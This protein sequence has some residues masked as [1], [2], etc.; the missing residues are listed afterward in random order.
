MAERGEVALMNKKVITA[1]A[2]EVAENPRARSA[3]LRGIV[4]GVSDERLNGKNR[5]MR[6]CAS[7]IDMQSS[8]IDH[9]TSNMR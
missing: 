8:N 5:T 9:L 6:M 2:S 1:S 7:I 3:K 4:V